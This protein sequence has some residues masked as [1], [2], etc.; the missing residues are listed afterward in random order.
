MADLNPLVVNAGCGCDSPDPQTPSECLIPEAFDFSV[1][2]ALV[3]QCGNCGELIIPPPPV[4]P[5]YDPKRVCWEWDPAYNAYWVTS[6]TDSGDRHLVVEIDPGC[7]AVMQ[8]CGN[9]VNEC[10]S[11]PCGTDPLDKH[12]EMSLTGGFNEYFWKPA[13][14]DPPAT[15]PLKFHVPTEYVD[16]VNSERGYVM[17]GQHNMPN[18]WYPMDF[19]QNGYHLTPASPFPQSEID[20]SNDPAGAL[21]A[22]C[23]GTAPLIKVETSIFPTGTVVDD[24]VVTN[25]GDQLDDE[26]AAVSL[27]IVASD[28]DDDVL[29]YGATG[30]PTSLSIDTGTGEITGTIDVGQGASSPFTVTVT[31]TDPDSNV[32]STTF[33]WVV[34]VP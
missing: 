25:P 22:N 1:D 16:R 9:C 19:V 7:G 26:G 3:K 18:Q 11:D 32:G 4:V 5:D 15:V 14:T 13:G 23:I 10:E 30:L 28:P 27:Q 20:L 8:D 33:T 6:P 2:V 31:A 17:L 12:M 21:I 29:V 24:P 34:T